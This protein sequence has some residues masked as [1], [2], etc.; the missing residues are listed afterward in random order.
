[1]VDDTPY[2][3]MNP[4][5]P[6]T[7][8]CSGLRIWK[9][10]YVCMA[11]VTSLRGQLVPP[12]FERR[13]HSNGHQLSTLRFMQTSW[14]LR[15]TVDALVGDERRKGADEEFQFFNVVSNQ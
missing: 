4:G 6:S 2:T 15:Y 7:C 13:Q 9:L 1:M 3:Q 14:P 10:R 11:E 12:S 5:S 8:G